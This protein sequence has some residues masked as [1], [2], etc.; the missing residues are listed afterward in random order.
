MGAD[1]ALYSVELF[2]AEV[3]PAFGAERAVPA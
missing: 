3:M 2:G 1:E